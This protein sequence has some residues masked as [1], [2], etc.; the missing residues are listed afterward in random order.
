M[1]LIVDTNIIISAKTEIMNNKQIIINNINRELRKIPV[2]YLANL[3]EII[4]IFREKIT[5]VKP[6][7]ES[8]EE[9]FLKLFGSWKSKYTGDELVKEI[10][11]SRKDKPRVIEL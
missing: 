9:E 3:Y 5:N 11:K 8:S 2:I 10:Y 7:I 6:K 1:N 4:H